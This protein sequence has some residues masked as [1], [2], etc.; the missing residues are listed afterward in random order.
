[1]PRGSW[2]L[3]PGAMAPVSN[4]SPR[5]ALSAVLTCGQRQLFYV[6]DPYF[7]ATREWPTG[8]Y[9]AISRPSEGCPDC[10]PRCAVSSVGRADRRTVARGLRTV[11]GGISARSEVAASPSH[12]RTASLRQGQLFHRY[13][14]AR[15][16]LPC[17]RECCAKNV[18]ASVTLSKQIACDGCMGCDV[19]PLVGPRG[20]R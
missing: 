17:P 6:G 18:S 13:H 11:G 3:K 10:T 14:C 19:H 16:R 20:R 4:L 7:G 2:I 15:T 8:V 12:R 9:H 5:L 1:M